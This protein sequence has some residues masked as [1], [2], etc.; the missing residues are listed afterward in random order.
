MAY[1]P[2]SQR[3]RS[4]S[5]QRREQN[6]RYSR[7]AGAEQIEHLP[8]LTSGVSSFAARRAVGFIEAISLAFC[9]SWM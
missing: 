3:A 7:T 1:A 8:R 9:P 4:T 6:G 5:A 2:R